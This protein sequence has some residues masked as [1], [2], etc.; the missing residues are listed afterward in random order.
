MRQHAVVERLAWDGT[1][2]ALAA[3]RRSRHV[4]RCFSVD[5]RHDN[6]V[7]FRPLRGSNAMIAFRGSAVVCTAPLPHPVPD[8]MITAGSFHVETGA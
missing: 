3:I 5:V 8:A 1:P 4:A 2:E 7:V 6:A